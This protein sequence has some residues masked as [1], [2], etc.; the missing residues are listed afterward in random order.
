[1]SD[2][3]PYAS[4]WTPPPATHAANGSVTAEYPIIAVPAERVG[5]E[6]AGPASAGP[7]PVRPESAVPESAVPESAVPE[8][9][10]PES[11]VPEPVGPDDFPPDWPDDRAPEPM[12]VD[13]RPVDAEALPRNA[14]AGRA[15][16]FGSTE[17]TTR[18]L[19]VP[20][21]GGRHQHP[22]SEPVSMFTPR[23]AGARPAAPENPAALIHPAGVAPPDQ[24]PPP[25]M[26]S[27][28]LADSATV[29]TP[30]IPRP[31]AAADSVE[32]SAPEEVSASAAV[33]RPA[34]SFP[35]SV[36]A[37]GS[38]APFGVAARDA[39]AEDGASPNGTVHRSPAAREMP[40]TTPAAAVFSPPGPVTSRRAS[41]TDPTSR[42][43]ARDRERV[44]PRLLPGPELPPGPSE[45]AR[46]DS[47]ELTSG[48]GLSGADIADDP[49]APRV[50]GADEDA[51]RQWDATHI[52]TADPGRT[53]V[54]EI[55]TSSS[56]NG[57]ATAA[58][59]ENDRPGGPTINGSTPAA[60]RTGLRVDFSAV[61]SVPIGSGQRSGPPDPAIQIDYDLV[62]VL[63]AEV[64]RLVIEALR[65]ETS[66]TNDQRRAITRELTE[67]VVRRNVDIR[68]RS[69][70][71]GA[72]T[73]PGYERALSDAVN[74]Y[75]TG[76]GRLQP[77]IDDPDVENI[78]VLG[79]RVR[80]VFANGVIDETSFT[81]AAS[82]EELISLLQRLA[83]RGG[84]TERSLST[85]KPIL[86]LRLPDGARLTVIY[87]VTSR[88]VVVIRR[89]RIRDV[90]LSDMVGMETITPTVKAFLEAAIT[91][92]MNIMIAGRANSGKT[93]L[94]RA[95]ADEIPREE[96]F[97]VMETVGELGLDTTG[98]HPWA[99]CF[100]ER[101]GFGEKGP[102]GRPEGELTIDDL[103]PHMLRLS[104]NRI[105]VGEVRAQEIV[106]M[107]DAMNTTYGSLCTI[108]SRDEHGVFDRLA[109]LLLRYGA[110]KSREGAYLTIG[111][112]L[113][114]VVY[115]N[116]EE[117]PGRR[118]KRYVSSIMEVHGLGEGAQLARSRIFG[119]GANGL[120]VP[121]GVRPSERRATELQRAGLDMRV[122]LNSAG[123]Y[124]MVDGR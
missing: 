83:E 82:D 41:P 24:M 116:M 35:A 86:H 28:A 120:A 59:H 108:H 124:Q 46:L 115:I 17:S 101:E 40:P 98:R 32:T 109:E 51:Q 72:V 119:P 96:W 123:S 8:P 89:H 49:L 50:Y 6:Q 47:L 67:A 5:P 97:A 25:I 3:H 74:A 27:S 90:S 85:A 7:D 48:R 45:S 12:G 9:V 95:I 66:V 2:E 58:V 33:H 70:E 117:V 64:S 13:V 110:S 91:A 62:S 118:P 87:T 78:M 93:T 19:D 112:A 53:G 15:G 94:L 43:P 21:P 107:F 34:T 14:F 1:V 122:L 60:P 31:A 69:G 18:S 81:A 68:V 38:P 30:I 63:Q 65:G 113:D 84:K 61:P 36:S 121:T 4:P 114:F 16:N 102:D 77:L 20:R 92:H 100:E 10:V 73:W 71:T 75:L 79:T 26:Y 23:A 76:L 105:I 22:G 111:N 103:F 42:G 39:P 104:T 106:A 37:F 80:V 56:M 44:D 29:A 52:R 88:P 57:H 54:A 11:A 99:V 55:R